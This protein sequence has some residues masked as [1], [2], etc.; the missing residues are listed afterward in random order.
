MAVAWRG[1]AVGSAATDIISR[2]RLIAD[3]L[4]PR[5]LSPNDSAD[6]AM[7]LQDLDLPDG[8]FTVHLIGAGRVD[9]RRRRHSISG[10]MR[11]AMRTD[12]GAPTIG[13]GRI[14]L[15]ITGP[16]GY[17]QHSNATSRSIWCA[18]RRRGCASDIPSGGSSTLAPDLSSFVPGSATATLTLGSLPFDTTGFM[19]ALHGIG[20]RFLEAS[21]SRGLPLTAFTGQAA[22]PDRKGRLARAVEDVL[23]DQRYDGAFGLWSSQEEAQPW[24]TAYATDFLLRA[25]AAG[26]AVPEPPLDSALSWLRHEVNNHP[27]ADQAQIYAAYMLALDGQAPAG[28][29]RVMDNNLTKITHPL[30]RAQLGAAFAR[31]GEPD[32]A[33]QAFESALKL[34][35][36]GGYFWWRGQDWN[37][38]YGTPLRDAWAVPAII[39]QSGMLR[40]QW[41]R[42]A[43]NLP[44]PGIPPDRLNAQ[45]LAFAALA[46]A[47]FA[48]KPETLSL[49]LDGK[50]VT[51]DQAMVRPIPAATPSPT[52]AH[53]R[54][55]R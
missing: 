12:L 43:A 49:T 40:A 54:F 18:R 24:L 38:G 19:Q 20:Y 50:A 47:D 48:G 6:V 26:A 29:I 51:S 11:H 41:P 9:G 15:N 1:D 4:L 5:F 14:T 25:R 34:H 28:A 44:G 27:S 13:T 8:H 3:L 31:I 22:G 16:D 55:R 35:N 39:R 10:P 46:A 42:L 36:R 30:A 53:R 37:A 45:E 21:V 33:R 2:H 52:T 23:D 7:M 17:T 32:Q